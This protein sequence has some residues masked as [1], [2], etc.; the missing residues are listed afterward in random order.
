MRHSRRRAMSTRSW[1][2]ALAADRAHGD[3]LVRCQWGRL[4]CLWTTPGLDW[5]D[6]NRIGLVRPSRRHRGPAAC[7][8]GCRAEAGLVVKVGGRVGMVLNAPMLAVG[9][10]QSGGGVPAMQ[11]SA[12]CPCPGAGGQV[13]LDESM[14]GRHSRGTLDDGLTRRRLPCPGANRSEHRNHAG[15]NIDDIGDE[16]TG[17]A[18]D[19]AD[20]GGLTRAH[21]NQC[22]M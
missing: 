15:M 7:P 2:R 8:A 1:R 20:L 5:P 14:W 3:R 12:R 17:A 9:V 6:A 21:G 18:R 11:P 13:P 4:V 22:P 19:I 10:R 16:E